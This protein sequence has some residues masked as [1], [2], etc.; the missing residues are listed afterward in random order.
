MLPF[1]R[2]F[3]FQNKTFA[4]RNSKLFS[5]SHDQFQ[6]QSFVVYKLEH[7]HC[8]EQW[9]L[10]NFPFHNHLKQTVTNKPASVI[11][12]HIFMHIHVITQC[13]HTGH[14]IAISTCVRNHTRTHNTLRDVTGWCGYHVTC[15]Y[16][17]CNYSNYTSYTKS[18][19]PL[20]NRNWKLFSSSHDQFQRQSLVV[21]KLE[22]AHC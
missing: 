5:W 18:P 22:H 10:G 7:A 12:Q 8:Y 9:T 17:L 15:L 21:N 4:T 6:R 20:P 2:P 14:V 1:Y 16:T 11:S 3:P 13:V 19:L